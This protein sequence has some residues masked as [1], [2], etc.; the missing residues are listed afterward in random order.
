MVKRVYV[1]KKPGFDVEAQQLF[2]ELRDILGVDGLEGVRVIRRYDVEGI[3][4]ELF[5]ES[6]SSVFSEPAVDEIAYELPVPADSKVFAVEY[7]PGQ[8]DQRAESASECIQLISQGERPA[9]RSANVYVLQGDVD[10]A[11]VDSVKGYVINPVEAREADLAE[12]DTLQQ[13]FPEPAP[14]EVLDGFLSLDDAGLAQF[15]DDRGLAMD[16]G[17]IRFCQRYFAEE[18][19]P[20][21][22]TEIRMIDT[23]WSDHCRHTTFGTVLDDVRIADANVQRAFDKYLEMRS[24]LGREEKP[25]CLMD[26]GTIGAKWLK[27]RGILTGLDESEEINA[28][29][30]RCKVDVRGEQQDWLYL[31]KNET[32]NHPTEIEPFGGAATCVGGA[33]RDPLSGRAYVYQA[34]RITGAADPTV[35]VADTIP[36]KLPQ[37]KLVTTA[38]QGYSSYGNQ[39]GLATGQV[40]EIYHPGYAAKRMEIGAVVGATPASDVRRETPAPGDV[41]VLLGG[42]TGR[43]GIG[44]AT[45]SSKAHST[46]SIE[47]CGAEVQKGNPPVERKIQRLFRNSEACRMIKR[48][49]DFGAGGVSVAIGE[50]ADGLDVYL[51]KVPKKYEGLDGTELAISESQERM[52]VALSVDDVDDFMALARAE[53]LEA[54]PVAVVSADPRVRM[55]WRGDTI[56][57]VSREFLASNGASKQASVEVPS[58]QDES[59]AE[60]ALDRAFEACDDLV[61]PMVEAVCRNGSMEETLCALMSDMNRASNKGL[62]ERF[63]STIGA[64]TVLMPFG[65]AT[66]LTPALAMVS[67]L[68]VLGGQTTTVS[69]LSWGFNPYLSDYDPFAGSYMAVLDSIA[70]LVATGFERRNMY[71]TFQEYFEKLRDD[72]KRWGKPVSAVLGALMA[73]VDFGVGAIGGKD[74]M[75]GSFEDLDVPPTLVSFATAVGDIDRVTSPELKEAGHELLWVCF[76]EPTPASVCAAFDAVEFLIG[77]GCVAACS[78]GGYS[79]LG[80][81]LFKMAVGNRLGVDLDGDVGFSDLFEEAYGTFVVELADGFDVASAIEM[82]GGAGMLEGVDALRLGTVVPSYLLIDFEQTADLAVV[83][84][85]WESGMEG[86][87]PYRTPADEKAALEEVPAVTYTAGPVIRYAGQPVARPQ[88]VIPVFPGTNCEYDTLAAF[89]RAGADVTVQVINNLSPCA[90]ADSTRD[91]VRNIREAQ[92][93]MLPGGFSGGDEPDGSAK[94]IASFFRSPEVA[95]AVRELLQKRDGLMLG[96]CNGFQALV[97]LGL[98]PYGD[99]V[100]ADQCEATLTFNT[101]GRH[102]SKLVDTR[103]A[104]NLSPWMAECEPG[105]I[106]TVAVSHGEGRFVAPAA[107]IDQMVERGQ[108]ATQYVDAQGKPSMDLL[109]NPN[110]SV[111]AIEGITSPDGRILG[112]MG[113]SERAGEG[114]YKNVPGNLY[115]PIFEAGVKYFL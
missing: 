109:Y 50:L 11:K 6:V 63:D 41:V 91:L 54:T 62:V 80:E 95:E 93:V 79:G 21:T 14:V 102:Q 56:V 23:Y 19:R 106:H 47:T 16:L 86:V 1:E 10:A 74:S 83:Q 70:K 113:H 105:S 65:G 17:D 46:S 104:S 71:L 77:K 45:G 43:D 108:V 115:Q 30:V 35:P 49:N 36:G 15:V 44:G 40:H 76:D 114:L 72:P 78:T 75:S 52:A 59:F 25:V 38:A 111:L 37:R 53:N 87:F 100:P 97:K 67:K 13:Q 60:C 84:E 101:I 55:H 28:C 31:F 33:I 107:L 3:S 103:T 99:I 26:M 5:E 4:D 12:V 18:G 39:I 34:M 69:G 58:P 112:K 81:T 61:N 73:Q 96:I 94:F 9:V 68:P 64:A 32:H 7:L 27:S 2:A 90:V 82:L 57:D 29:T 8:F 42:R 92:I 22:I 98:V 20:P 88:V 48:C 110:G 51:D 89:K 24:E 85:A 66:Q